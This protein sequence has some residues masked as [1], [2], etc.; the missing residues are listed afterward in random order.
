MK[1]R[2]TSLFAVLVTAGALSLATSNLAQEQVADSN[3]NVAVT[4]PA[5]T[6]NHP[7]V[8][9]DEAHNNFHSAQGRYKPLADLLA[10]DGYDVSRNTQTFNRESLKGIRVLII[11]NALAS[12]A[13]ANNSSSAFT[14]QEADY[15]RDWVEEGGSLLLIADHVPFG[16]AA[17][18]IA[19]RFNIQ[20]G[21]GI[22]FDRRANTD[23]GPTTMVFSRENTFLGTHPLMQG[24]SDSEV[25]KRVVTFSGQ[26]VSVPDG[27]TALLKFS[28]SAREA[29]TSIQLEAALNGQA[30]DIPS[31][32]SLAQAVVL[33][34]GRGRLAVAGEAAML[35]AQVVRFESAGRK[36]E[37]KMGMNVAGND[38]R[39][40]ALNILHWLSG[41]LD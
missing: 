21:K 4:M 5:Y 25:I 11:A 31:V 10:N 40:F 3:F 20:M 15:V 33:K 26:S 16:N 28:A 27:A 7:T 29:P 24:R 6:S 39:Q 38:N 32:S 41:L 9:I 18:S 8:T 13:T 22:V 37:I 34:V 1:P 19:R 14:E 35:T 17:E 2:G 23:G 12:D 30:T 36:E